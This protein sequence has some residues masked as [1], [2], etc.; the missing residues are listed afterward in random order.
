MPTLTLR[1][2]WAAF[3]AALLSLAQPAAAE[4]GR[5]GF[6]VYAEADGSCLTP[7]P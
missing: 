3:C 4:G 1:A 5:S 2:A 6:T 7:I